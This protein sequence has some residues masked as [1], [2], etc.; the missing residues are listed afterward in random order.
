MASNALHTSL[1]GECTR[2]AT[3]STSEHLVH[4]KHGCGCLSLSSLM[5]SKSCD[6]CCRTTETA[7]STAAFR[8]TA[9][10]L[11]VQLYRDF[12]RSAKLLAI[13]RES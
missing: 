4:D 12:V 7:F 6:D 11:S 2:T 10:R 8:L 3:K 1:S 5:A 13:G 9:P